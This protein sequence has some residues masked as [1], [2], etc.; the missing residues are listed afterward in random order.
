MALAQ[1][2]FDGGINAVAASNCGSTLGVTG[3]I[4]ASAGLTSTATGITSSITG[5]SKANFTANATTGST[6]SGITFSDAGTAKWGIFKETTN[7]LNI[8]DTVNSVSQVT[9]TAGLATAGTVVVNLTTAATTT[10]SGAFQV[11]GGVGITG[12]AWIGGLANIAGT[13]TTGAITVTTS[14]SVALTANSS[15]TVLATF[16][17]SSSGSGISINMT[18]VS[19]AKEWRIGDAIGSSNGFLV[20]YDWTSGYPV[21]SFSG[22][23]LA[24]GIAAFRNITGVSL[25]T[26]GSIGINGAS[27]FAQP[28]GF[29]TPSAL[30]RVS[31]FPGTGA[32]LAQCGGAISDLLTVLKSYGFLGA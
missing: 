16:V 1:N 31:S 28:T 8:F 13:L 30:G 10:T 23:T 11:K 17:G 29:G 19:G 24:N 2:V 26:T 9:C 15:S 25:V 6:Q 22:T 27:A 4:T 12:A 32:T 18:A 3:L 7:T 14:S 5:S 21:A 20:I